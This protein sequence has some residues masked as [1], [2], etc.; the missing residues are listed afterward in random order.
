MFGYDDPPGGHAEVAFYRVLVNEEALIGAIG[1][2][3]ALMQARLGPGRLHH[4][5]RL[6]G[7]GDRAIEEMRKRGT[8]RE[9]YGKSLLSLE[10]NSERLARCRVIVQRST[11]LVLHAAAVFD[12]HLASHGRKPSSELL[13][14]LAVVKV[15][16]PGSMQSCL[17]CAIQLHGGGGLSFDHPLA[18]MWTACRTLRIVDGADEVHLRNLAKL[19]R[20]FQNPIDS[21]VKLISKL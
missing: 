1:S 15:D 18:V 19:E 2:G 17:D 9:L 8:S 14:A 6:V 11:L 21:P 13:R 10:G 12:E 5:A 4:C 16:V 20:T 7:H 3:F